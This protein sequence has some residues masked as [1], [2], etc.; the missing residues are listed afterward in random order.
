MIILHA[1]PLRWTR[2]SGLNASLL[3]LV[4]AQNRLQGVRAGMTLT[5][6]RPGS[7][8]DVDFPLFD[9]KPI[10]QVADRLN[11]PAPFDRP[12]LV[13]FNSTYIPFHAVLAAKLRRL[14]IPYILCPHGGMTRAAGRQRW[15]KKQVA[16][17]VFFN[18]LVAGAEALHC[19]TRG[20]AEATALW[21]KPTFIVGNGISLPPESQLAAPGRSERLRLGFVG[22]I[23][24]RHKGLDW[25]LEACRLVATELRQRGACLELWGPD[26]R[27]ALP[28]LDAYV[29]QHQLEDV[30]KLP[31]PTLGE[32]K[33]ALLGQLDVFL[34]TSRWEGHPMAVL[35]ALAY[36]LPCLLTPGTNLADDVAHA[37]AG[38]NV[39]PNPAGIAEG[40]RQVLTTPRRELRQAGA[41]ARAFAHREFHWP[42]IA[43]RLVEQYR[44]IVAPLC[45]RQRTAA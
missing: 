37:G 4:S 42:R 27:G 3:G 19:L 14:R 13:V 8:P 44:A 6:S 29:R 34:H 31:G 35:E 5:Q 40:L 2:I 1:A 45:V 33:W 32:A 21:R 43:A 39:A 9:R 16:N 15:L 25:L 11:L 22:R 20:E 36:G 18:R 26:D 41:S 17:L 7:P 28:R 38:W 23:D 30:V 10:L 24:P 12:D